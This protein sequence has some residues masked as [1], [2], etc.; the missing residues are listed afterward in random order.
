MPNRSTRPA[1]A[2]GGGAGAERLLTYLRPLVNFA[3]HELWAREAAGDLPRGTVAPDDLVAAAAIDA[4]RQPPEE[5]DRL[6]YPRLRRL[7]RRALAREVAAAAQRRRERSLDE[8]VGTTWPDEEGRPPRRLID[9]LPDPTAPV[10][11]QVVESLEFQ[12]ALAALL[13]QLPAEWREPFVLHV[14]D[15]LPLRQVARIEGLSLAEVRERVERA[16]A[17]LRARLAEEYEE[18]A[19][20]PPSETLFTLMERVEPTPAC[21]ARVQQELAAAP[22]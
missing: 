13:C 16:R 9:I 10:P 2:V 8:P 12:R 3:R 18:L 11:D 15:G 7:V 4:L 6:S 1:S 22:S 5:A 21:V 14:V 19:G 17:F 20:P